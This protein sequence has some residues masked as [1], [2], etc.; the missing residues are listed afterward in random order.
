MLNN[1][2]EIL[3]TIN[4]IEKDNFDVRTITMG[5]SLFDCITGDG[6]K[7]ADKVYDK[8]TKAAKN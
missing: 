4:M 7:T 8:I 2:N 6:K 1:R 3:E 5:V